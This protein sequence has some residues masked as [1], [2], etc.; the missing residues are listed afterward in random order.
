MKRK[1]DAAQ[2][3]EMIAVGKVSKSVGIR[4][5]VKV[6]P[7]TDDPQRFNGLQSVWLGTSEAPLE[8]LNVV[9]VRVERSSVALRLE[10]V[11][12]R[13]A[14]D[15]KRGKIVYVAEE[16]AVTPP[17]G[18]YFIH[19][20]IGM[21][22]R[23]E[24]GEVVGAVKEVLQLPANDVWVV[25]KGEKEILIPAI[26]QVIKSVDLKRRAIVIHAIEGLLD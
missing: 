4:G 6:V 12:S 1:R 7:F 5:E 17:K 16:E 15:A 3:T 18:S 11:D 23:T 13:T 10:G 19:D 25:M 24:S 14:A 22:V 9:S 21:D 26:K 2:K 20:I 8:H